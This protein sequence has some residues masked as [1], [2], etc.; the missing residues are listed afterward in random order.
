MQKLFCRIKYTVQYCQK[1][2]VC[3]CDQKQIH[4]YL[5]D[6]YIKKKNQRAQ[7]QLLQLHLLS[8]QPVRYSHV[9][10]LAEWQDFLIQIDF[11]LELEMTSSPEI[12]PLF[13]QTQAMCKTWRRSCSVLVWWLQRGMGRCSAP[14]NQ[15][16]ASRAEWI[17]A[18]PL[19]VILPLI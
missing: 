15:T 7:R 9:T 18:A 4:W 10:V 14:Q 8:N 17:S 19:L 16:Q 3:G 2:V 1:Q 13:V 5:I 11:W 6:W 12:A